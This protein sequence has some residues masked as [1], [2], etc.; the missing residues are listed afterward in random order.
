M[1][2]VLEGLNASNGFICCINHFP[3]FGT[4]NAILGS[5][6]KK[7]KGFSVIILFAAL[8]MMSCKTNKGNG[9]AETT[10]PESLEDLDPNQEEGAIN[11]PNDVIVIDIET[12]VI[13]DPEYTAPEKNDPFTVKSASIKG[14]VLSLKVS[15]SGGCNDH[16]FKAITNRTYMKSMPPKLGITIE[17]NANGDMCKALKTETLTF[18]LVPIGNVVLKTPL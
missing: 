13:V 12:P 6:A 1:L 11:Q 3:I 8:A 14:D 2:L 9:S 16:E 4:V 10:G 18:N 7:M 15:Y 17:H 5:K